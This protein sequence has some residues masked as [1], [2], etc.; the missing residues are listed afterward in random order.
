[1]RIFRGLVAGAVSGVLVVGAA[2]L[3]SITTATAATASPRSVLGTSRF[4]T[5][6]FGPLARSAR[7]DRRQVIHRQAIRP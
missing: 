2:G 3:L 7:R 5:M 1:M 4:S 6:C